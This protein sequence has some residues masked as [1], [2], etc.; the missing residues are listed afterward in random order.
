M[1]GERG[2]EIAVTLAAHDGGDALSPCSPPHHDRRIRLNERTDD[3]GLRLREA[4]RNDHRRIA[5]P[6]RPDSRSSR[7]RLQDPSLGIAGTGQLPESS[8]AGTS[9]P[10]GQPSPPRRGQSGAGGQ[11]LECGRL[12]AGAQGGTGGRL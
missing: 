12:V 3:R 9:R 7:Q 2:I 1:L 5:E 10:D 11:H 8:G 6:H 4:E